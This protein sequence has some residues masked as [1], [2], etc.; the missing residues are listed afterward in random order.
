MIACRVAAVALLIMIVG[1][2]PTTSPSAVASTP[3]GA[4]SAG[5]G[6]VLSLHYEVSVPES[7]DSISVR[8]CVDGPRPLRLMAASR[9]MAVALVELSVEGPSSGDALAT[10]SSPLDLPPLG[11]DDCVRYRI[12]P[13]AVRGFMR[14]GQRIGEALMVDTRMWM[15]RPPNWDAGTRVSARFDLPDGFSVSLPWHRDGDLFTADASA[16][17]FAAN[18]VFGRFEVERFEAAGAD[19]EVVVPAGL[20]D[21][22][23]AVMTPWIRGAVTAVADVFE[24]FPADRLQVVLVPR[25][26][27]RSAIGFGMLR[28]GGGASVHLVVS[29]DAR[30][31][32]L[33]TSWTAIHEFSHL[34]HFFVDKRDA[35]LSEGLA[36]YYQ[37]VLRARAGLLPVDE[38]WLRIHRGCLKGRATDL[39]LAEESAGM[40]ASHAFSRVYWAG[41]AMSLQADVAMRS[42]ASQP[43]SLDDALRRL[44]GCCGVVARP[45][46]A[47]KTLERLD[48]LTDTKVFSRLLQRVETG[49]MPDLAETFAY[50]G[51]RVTDDQVAYFDA[52]GSTIRDAIMAARKP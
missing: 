20:D 4:R 35:W 27:G 42:H 45:W 19:I 5:R 32:E 28:R 8:M 29:S 7:L 31:P 34:L 43:G 30:L 11:P 26:G 10:G 24:R 1:C 9:N 47:R 48:E 33:R 18:S 12:D 23:R 50:L 22:T 51:I 46:T 25:P 15:W 16:L 3:S 41:A 21:S 2:A 37:E 49:R 40:F 36:T 44:N 52:P 6:P 14:P 17:G 13:G 38:A 39:S